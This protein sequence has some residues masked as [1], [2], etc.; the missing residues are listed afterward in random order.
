MSRPSWGRTVRITL[1]VIVWLGALAGGSWG[2][3]ALTGPEHTTSWLAQVWKATAG[4]ARW[5]PFRCQEPLWL[6]VGDPVYQKTTNGSLRLAGHVYLVRDL[7]N[8]VVSEGWTTQGQV[9]LTPD[10]SWPVERLE[11]YRADLS[12]QAGMEM[13]FPPE[14]R[15][16]LIRLLSQTWQEQGD[17]LVKLMQPVVME[18]L[19]RSAPVVQEE[20]TAALNRRADQV[21]QL[22]QKWQSQIVQKRLVPV[23]EKEVGPILQQHAVPL[24]RKLG[25]ELWARVSLWRFTVAALLDMVQPD[26]KRLEKEFE[27]FVRKEVMPVLKEHS[28][29]IMATAVEVVRQAWNRPAV[30]QAF[31]EALS[32]MVQDPQLQQLTQEVFQE[33]VLEN[34]RVHQA[35]AEAFRSPKSQKALSQL[36]QRLE[37]V[38]RRIG[39]LLLGTPE[40]GLTPELTRLLRLHVFGKDRRWLVL[41]P[42]EKGLREVPLVPG[43]SPAPLPPVPRARSATPPPN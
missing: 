29:E 36:A 17:E 8:R 11:Y 30:R 35:L 14:K 39:E 20:L 2:L 19:H 22:L 18:A 6:R 15:Q 21:Q 7:Q 42:S 31:Q 40:K 28:D 32:E 24:A 10:A 27:K 1:G 33:A 25:L 5:V 43:R 9:Y 41:V 3:L 13:L 23:L 38:A 37:P 12:I 4:E 26:E 34:P 16:E